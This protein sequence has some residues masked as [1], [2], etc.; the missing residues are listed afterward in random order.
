MKIWLKLL[1][2]TAAGILAG[3]FFP[4]VW[5]DIKVIEQLS[6]VA[7]NIGRF[8]IF[9]L[10]FFSVVTGIHSL[11]QK[12]KVL[13][14]LSRSVLYMVIVSALLSVFGT[15]S[16]LLLSPERIPVF[17]QE[18]S[19]ITLPSFYETILSI[20]PTNFFSVFFQDGNQI[21]PIFIM[22][23]L[24]GFNMNF[25]KVITRA[26]VQ[27]FESI[28]GIFY[29]INSFIN[30][31]MGFFIFPM[32]W[33]ITEQ[34]ISTAEIEV[35]RQMLFAIAADILILVFIIYP[36][37]L[38]FATGRKN[39]YKWIY[40]ALAPALAAIASGD[41][42]FC[43]SLQI[44]NS[45]ANMGSKPEAATVSLPLLSVFSKAGT[46]MVTSI[47]FIVILKSYSSLGLN[48][49]GVIWVST[50]AFLSSFIV[51]PFPGTGV[52]VAVSLLCSI[53]GRGIE[54]GYLILKP[55]LPI[56][57]SASV[58]MDTLTNSLI[59]MVASRNA[60]LHEEIPAAKF[61]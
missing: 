20:F 29:H 1:I 44:K 22:A 10:V 58:L 21:L 46:A 36:I 14:I 54:E 8:I 60:G 49:S 57:F 52:F 43:L 2:G 25:D 23:V 26:T 51:G 39:P 42:L 18:S 35:F 13:G 5:S 31:L 24:I 3:L 48:F 11:V 56:L 16:V 53:Y 17:I 41:S 9:P 6:T 4:D 28:S 27:L 37:I 7:I 32:A 47:S 61:K 38:Y 40:A 19:H 55:I 15:I 12:K 59:S 34:I 33:F 50:F 30:E 45:S